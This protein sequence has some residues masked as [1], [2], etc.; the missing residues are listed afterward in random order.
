MPRLNPPLYVF[1]GS[2]APATTTTRPLS[3][4]V[5]F[6]SYRRSITTARAPP[7]PIVE[8][9]PEPTCPCRSTPKLDLEIDRT[10][11]LNGSMS[12]YAQHL[13]ISTGQ[14][15]WTSRIEDEHNNGTSWGKVI[16][17][18]KALL[19]RHG[20]FHDPFNNILVNTSSFAPGQESGQRQDQSNKRVDGVEA[21]VFPSFRRFRHLVP[22]TEGRDTTT[23]SS[24]HSSADSRSGTLRDF[25]RGYLLPEPNRLH[26]IYKDI[27]DHERAAKTRDAAA[28]T[29]FHSWPIT[30]PTILICS[31]HQRDSRCGILGPLLHDEFRRYVNQRKPDENGVK[32][33]TPRSPGDFVA[34]EDG[35]SGGSEPA[36]QEGILESQVQ[37]SDSTAMSSI[38]NT[39]ASPSN[40]KQ[41]HVNVGMISHVG[42]HKWAGNVIVYIPPTFTT[43]RCKTSD[44]QPPPSDMSQRASG[45]P[46]PH[47][48]R[49]MGIWYG[50][51]EPKHVEG[52]IEQTVVGGKVIEELF[53]GGISATGEI[54]RL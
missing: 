20:Q 29:K 2:S 37:S 32:L 10:K 38:S 43:A 45:V 19:G 40:S 25:V 3:R 46:P 34:S 44:N 12:P 6:S 31:H 30:N 8:T 51:V 9:C 16:G 18:V 50:R 39:G 22:L 48:L 21:L 42:G 35:G 24:S 41:A 7:F 15:D 28:A 26:P 5:A 14:S 52:I 36:R 49:G 4:C 23:N 11:N 54:L 47:P 17:D 53:R 27:P 13:L 1:P 33:V